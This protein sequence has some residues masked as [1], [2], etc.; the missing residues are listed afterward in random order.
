MN[1]LPPCL[2]GLEHILQLLKLMY[3]APAT[4]AYHLSVW[5]KIGRTVHPLIHR[6]AR[7][8]ETPLSAVQRWWLR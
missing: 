2:L 7:F 6:Y 3:H 8:L 1:F 4:A 5:T